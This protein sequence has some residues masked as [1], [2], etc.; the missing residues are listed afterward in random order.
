MIRQELIGRIFVDGNAFAPDN[1]PLGG[2]GLA[3]SVPWKRAPYVEALRRVIY[4]W[5]LRGREPP[6]IEVTRMTP[7]TEILSVELALIEIFIQTFFDT[8]GRAPCVPHLAPPHG[9]EKDRPGHTTPLALAPI[10][11]SSKTRHPNEPP[12]QPFDAAAAAAK[13]PREHSQNAARVEDIIAKRRREDMQSGSLDDAAR[14]FRGEAFLRASPNP[15]PR[16]REEQ[17]R[18]HRDN[19]PTPR[20]EHDHARAF[21]PPPVPNCARPASHSR[22]PMSAPTARGRQH[23]HVSRD[24][25][26]EVFGGW[27]V[28]PSPEVTGNW[29]VPQPP[30]QCGDWGVPLAG[31]QYGAGPSRGHSTQ[32]APPVESTWGAPGLQEEEP[33]AGPSGVEPFEMPPRILKN[34]ARVARRLARGGPGRRQRR[35]ARENDAV[36]VGPGGE[37]IYYDILD[38]NV[39]VPYTSSGEED[40]GDIFR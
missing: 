24:A 19:S 25:P 40:V 37:L 14:P 9:P 12:R 13:R 29:G 39:E 33:R 6:S 23:E 35:R 20:V 27:G 32:H 8:A 4:R 34:Q 2:V 38:D 22:E 17:H 11:K 21:A 7:V 3:D 10:P 26:R 1:I 16:N 28:P 30:A 31:H 36:R 5:P 18:P 15:P